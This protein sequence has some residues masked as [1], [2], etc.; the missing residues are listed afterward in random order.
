VC[1]L[2]RSSHEPL[3]QPKGRNSVLTCKHRGPGLPLHRRPLSSEG[4]PSC[5]S[6]CQNLLSEIP[7]ALPPGSAV[8]SKILVWPLRSHTPDFTQRTGRLLPFRASKPPPVMVLPRASRLLRTWQFLAGCFFF[9]LLPLE[10]FQDSISLPSMA[11]TIR[12]NSFRHQNQN[13]EIP[14]SVSV[15]AEARMN[16]N[17]RAKGTWC[18]PLPCLSPRRD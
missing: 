13:R 2:V 9:L 10:K 3:G 12:S 16:L 18:R 1:L 8:S 17:L 11:P 14:H 6:W 7:N 5:P 15:A 4:D